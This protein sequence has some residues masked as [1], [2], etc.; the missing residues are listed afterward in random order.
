[1][2]AGVP[3]EN[4]VTDGMV[5]SLDGCPIVHSVKYIT[6][7]DII[8][9]TREGH[10]SMI[11]E[12]E[13]QL[14]CRPDVIVASVGGGG[15]LTGIIQGMRKVGWNDVPVVAMETEGAESYYEAVKEGKLVTLPAITR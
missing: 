10:S 9:I 7:P 5:A 13:Q 3:P 11:V 14:P 2:T 8:V 4:Y 15:L 6:Q 1:M 12:A